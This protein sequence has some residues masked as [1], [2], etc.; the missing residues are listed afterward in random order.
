MV[1][2]VEVE[3]EVRE[4]GEDGVKEVVGAVVG[5]G[6][7]EEVEGDVFGAGG[8]VEDGEDGGDGAS[9]V[10]GVEGHGDVD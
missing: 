2:A 6:E 10:G 4:C 5:G 9:E 3:G 8:V 1:E 7:G